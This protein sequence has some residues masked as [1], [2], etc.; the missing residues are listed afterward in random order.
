MP[1]S[2]LSDRRHALR[3]RRS[4]FF[5]EQR[6]PVQQ[7]PLVQIR[8]RR[9]D[10]PDVVTLAL[11]QPPH[12]RPIQENSRAPDRR[13]ERKTSHVERTHIRHGRKIVARNETTRRLSPRRR[14][15]LAH[16]DSS[17]RRRRDSRDGSRRRSAHATTIG[18]RLRRVGETT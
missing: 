14:T 12:G 8:S 17:R 5:A 9:V 6:T 2:G 18:R 13:M 16:V 11:S 3:S 4:S 15:Q 1:S 10:R 7:P